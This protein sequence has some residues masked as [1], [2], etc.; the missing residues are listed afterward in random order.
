M[1]VTITNTS[2]ATINDLQTLTGGVG[3]SALNAVGGQRNNPLPY[4]FGHI[5][6]LANAA[7]SVLPMHPA[8]WRRKRVP[9]MAMQPST[10]WNQMVQANTVT[11]AVAAEPGRT[12]SEEL[13]MNAV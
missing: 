13:Y 4:P 12:D 11:I 5:G 6:A 1:I 3:V 7:T 8:D 10:Q 2:G 9:S